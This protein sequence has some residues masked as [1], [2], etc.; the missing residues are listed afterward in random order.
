M[1]IVLTRALDLVRV[2]AEDAAMR[3]DPVLREFVGL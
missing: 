3:E 2:V 1:H